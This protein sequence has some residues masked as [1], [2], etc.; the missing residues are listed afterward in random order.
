MSKVRNV[1]IED[2]DAGFI[3]ALKRDY[4]Q[5]GVYFR[6]FHPETVFLSKTIKP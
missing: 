4:A 2:I 6:L 5:T 1:N 3:A